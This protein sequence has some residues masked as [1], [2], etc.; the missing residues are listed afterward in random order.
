[1]AADYAYRARRCL[2]EAGLSLREADYPGVVRRSQEALELAVKALLRYHGIE[3]PHEHDVGD[4]LPELKGKVGSNLE[5]ILQDLKELLGELSKLRG[6]AMYGYER[7]GIPPSRVFSAKYAQETFAKVSSL[8]N[9][10][11]AALA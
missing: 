1:M 4:A 11:L 7:E 5:V 8:V 3:Y 9:E 2:R 10:C 6:P